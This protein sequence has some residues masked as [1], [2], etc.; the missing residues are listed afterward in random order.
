MPSSTKLTK[1]GNS[2]LKPILK[3]AGGKRQLLP[4]ILP[5]IPNDASLYIEPFLGGGAVLL[6]AQPSKAIVNDKNSELINV[7]H[8][9]RVRLDELI[10]LLEKHSKKNSKDY[11]YKIR[12]LDRNNDFPSL[13]NITKAARNIYLNKTCFN[14]PQ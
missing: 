9:V 1:K 13:G 11:F 10:S 8:V 3:W 4:D 2:F 7:Y 5:F 14:V 12:A 6:A